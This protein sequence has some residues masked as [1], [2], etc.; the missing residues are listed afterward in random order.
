MSYETQSCDHYLLLKPDNASF[1]DLFRFLF[2][3]ESETSRFI[4]ST[5]ELK[6]DFWRRWFIF[7]SLFVQKLLLKV[8]NPMVQIGHVFEFWLNLLSSN[9]GL[10]KLLTNFLTGNLVRPNSSSATFTSVLGNLDQ[11]VELD[12]SIKYGNR[13]YNASLSIMASK[14]SYENEAFVQT[15]IKDHWNMEYL[16]FYNFWNDYLGQPATQAIMFQDTMDDPNLIVVAF[17]G[18]H[19]F[20]P[21]DWR[22]DVDLSWFELEGV[23]KIH[24]GF[25]KALGLQKDKGWPKEIEQGNNQRQFAYYE[26]R[27]R[28]RDL[29][30]K[31]EKAKFIVTGHSLGAALAILFLTVLAKHEEEWLMDKLEGVYTFGQPRVGDSQM[32]DYMKKKLK[33]YNVRY[34][35]FVYCN[36]IVPRIPYDDETRFFTHFG[37]CLYYNSFYKGKVLPEEPNKNYFSVSWAIYKYLNAVWELI[38]SFIIPYMMGP[39][40]KEGWLMTMMRMIG[41]VIPGFADHCPQDYVNATRLGSLPPCLHQ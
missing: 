8:G 20:D 32:G 23:G 24:S 39:E 22:T 35:R 19:P 21:E 2:S 36:D 34:L 14:L 31:N 28:L 18:T 17:R 6:G 25:M 27:Q 4:E 5:E 26:I 38:R 3:S 37:P 15:I 30:Q 16:G 40:Y 41:L 11:R 13:K 9:G 10:L 29:L 1:G 33:Q 7:N 12:K